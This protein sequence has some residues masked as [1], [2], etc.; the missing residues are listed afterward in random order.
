ML[1]D[2]LSHIF[3]EVVL[4]LSKQAVATPVQQK[5][6]AGGSHELLFVSDPAGCWPGSTR[7][8]LL[9]RRQS[10]LRILRTGDSGDMAA[11]PVGANK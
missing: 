1:L 7:W 10:T 8:H 2:F 5:E 9:L 4:L 3:T 11:L 6:E